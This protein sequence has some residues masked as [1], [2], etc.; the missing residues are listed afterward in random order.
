[1]L[2]SLEAAPAQ[3]KWDCDTGE[4]KEA[5]RDRNAVGPAMQDMVRA[6]SSAKAGLRAGQAC[7]VGFG[8]RDM[9]SKSHTMVQHQA[10][11]CAQRA[12]SDAWAALLKK[13]DC[14]D[15]RANRDKASSECC[16][17]CRRWLCLWGP[18]HIGGG[19]MQLMLKCFVGDRGSSNSG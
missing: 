15:C 5:A 17:P 14:L 18:Q 3:Q 16:W 1:M 9:V 4:W 11:P 8:A 7:S 6:Q 19:W 13:R 2:Q 12:A 10:G